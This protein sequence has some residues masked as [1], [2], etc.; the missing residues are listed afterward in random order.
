MTVVEPAYFQQTVGRLRGRGHEVRHFALLARRETVVGRL[1]TRGLGHAARAVG[2]REAPLRRESF[3]MGKLDLCLERLRGPEFAEHVWTDR[4]GVPE[5]A[6][7]IAASA[8]LDIAPNTDGPLRGRLRRALV[9]ARH[10][11]LG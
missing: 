9:S 4:I 3:A 7:R 6:S 10:I 5:V 11:R 8:G 2:G 1:R